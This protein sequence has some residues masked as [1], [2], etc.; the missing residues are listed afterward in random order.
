MWSGALLGG[1]GGKRG[2]ALLD[3]V[4]AA[5]RALHLT[6]FVFHEGQ[7]LVE[8]FLA[9][10]A[11]EFVVGHTDLHSFEN[12]D[13]RIL[14]PLVDRFNMGSDHAF[15]VI[16]SGIFQEIWVSDSARLRWLKLA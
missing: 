9:V 2:P 12:G 8:E 14:D 5:V 16:W 7:N 10:T 11:E 13:G 3:V 6:L 15:C 1:D 4:A